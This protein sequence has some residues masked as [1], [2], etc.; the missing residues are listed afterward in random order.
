MFEL[1]KRIAPC[2][3]KMSTT[4][5]FLSLLLSAKDAHPTVFEIPFT[6]M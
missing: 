2:E 4:K 5:L 3:I 1:T 6:V